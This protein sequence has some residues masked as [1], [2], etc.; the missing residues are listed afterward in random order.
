MM[1][2]SFFVQ[3]PLVTRCLY[4]LP[5]PSCIHPLSLLSSRPLRPHES[6]YIPFILPPS[7]L[8]SF[9]PFIYRTINFP[10]TSSFSSHLLTFPPLHF[11]FLWPSYTYKSHSLLTISPSYRLISQRPSLSPFP[12][13][14]SPSH[15]PFNTLPLPLL[16]VKSLSV[17]KHHYKFSSRMTKTRVEESNVWKE[18]WW[19]K[20]NGGREREK[21]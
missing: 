13:H 2:K 1:I 9:S 6:P 14:L 10:F 19:G 17:S 20:G 18:E 5:S 21:K 3:R 4:T 8:P 11:P 12:I 15:H 7:T 16:K